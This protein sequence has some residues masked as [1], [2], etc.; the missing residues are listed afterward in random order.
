MIISIIMIVNLN[1]K[2]IIPIITE[3]TDV[4][5]SKYRSGQ[6]RNSVC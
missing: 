2:I 5:D 3:L 6:L 1:I 4:L